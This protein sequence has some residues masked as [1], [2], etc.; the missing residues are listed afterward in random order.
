MKDFVVNYAAREDYWREISSIV[1]A[2]DLLASKDLIT[3]S[4]LH[5][6]FRK[7]AADPLL[8]LGSQLGLESMAYQWGMLDW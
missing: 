4:E 7:L 3:E 6:T 5:E 8:S 1:W 2:L